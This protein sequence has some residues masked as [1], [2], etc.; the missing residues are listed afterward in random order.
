MLMLYR[1]PGAWVVLLLSNLSNS[2][3]ICLERFHFLGSVLQRALLLHFIKRRTKFLASLR[4]FLYTVHSRLWQGS[5]AVTDTPRIRVSPFIDS[6]G[7][8]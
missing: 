1:M 8:A 4:A 3:E 2:H 6:S 7:Y 5:Q